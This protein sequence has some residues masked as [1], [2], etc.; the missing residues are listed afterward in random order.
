M[1]FP[2][3]WSKTSGRIH[4]K[5]WKK[6]Y[7]FRGGLGTWLDG[8]SGRL[9]FC[10]DLFSLPP[11]F[12]PFNFWNMSE[13]HVQKLDR[14]KNQISTPITKFW[15]YIVL[16]LPGSFSCHLC[17]FLWDFQFFPECN[18]RCRLLRP[19]VWRKYFSLDDLLFHLDRFSVLRLWNNQ[20]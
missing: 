8:G 14:W 20:S 19:S 11:S 18:L 10:T 12:P 4:K 16:E 13:L 6:D 7:H 3:I 1:M 17:K 9:R 2:Y 15:S 5:L